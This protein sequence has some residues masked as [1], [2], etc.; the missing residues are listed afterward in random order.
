[1]ILK[2]KKALLPRNYRKKI[3]DRDL[4]LFYYLYKYKVANAEQIKRDVFKNISYKTVSRRLKKLRELNLLQVRSIIVGNHSQYIYSIGKEALECIAPKTDYLIDNPI[5]NS[6]S[7]DHDLVLVDILERISKYSSVRE[8]IT[9][10]MLQSCTEFKQD[11]LTRDFVEV[12]SDALVRVEKNDKEYNLAF[13]Y[14]RTS[15]SRFRYEQKLK[16]YYNCSNIISVLYLCP[17]ERT[18]NILKTLDQKCHG[19]EKVK[20]RFCSIQSISIDSKKMIFTSFEGKNTTL[21]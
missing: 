5:F 19:S 1:M 2:K 7:V 13:E 14:D 3:G 11:K 21:Q 17:N 8:V 10:N 18:V 9:E 6:D 4:N 20:F 12:R 15:K 16:D